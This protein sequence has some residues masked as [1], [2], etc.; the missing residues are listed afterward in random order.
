MSIKKYFISLLIVLLLV[1]MF[2]PLLVSCSSCGGSVTYVTSPREYQGDDTTRGTDTPEYYVGNIS[3]KVFHRPDCN[4][5][6]LM[7][8]GN[9]VTLHGTRDNALARGYTPCGI[10]TP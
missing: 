6:P 2:C 1:S 4:R 9:K 7:N 8:P 5:I 10:C 3:S